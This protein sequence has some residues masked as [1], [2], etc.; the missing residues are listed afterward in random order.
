GEGKGKGGTLALRMRARVRSR[1]DQL[2][3]GLESLL[4]QHGFR[5]VHDLFV[6]WQQRTDELRERLDAGVRGRLTVARERLARA[7]SAYGFREALPRRL[8]QAGAP[9]GATRAGLGEGRG[10]RG[11][12]ER[13]A[14]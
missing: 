8:A 11:G 10:G 5:R 2:R 12:A 13:P 14:A 6:H 4:R 3:R 1:L 9:P 7:R